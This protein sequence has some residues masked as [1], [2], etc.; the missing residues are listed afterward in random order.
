MAR[1]TSRLRSAALPLLAVAAV[2]APPDAGAQT[3]ALGVMLG[4]VSSAHARSR[5][6]GSKRHA[7]FMVGAWIDVATPRPWLSVTAE[8]ALARRGAVYPFDDGFDR[9]LDVDYLTAALLPTL[10]I[11][12]GP[13]ALVGYAGPSVDVLIRSGASIELQDA[14]RSG[15]GQVLG[16]VAGG[17][18]QYR[19]GRAT[20]RLE[21][22]VH[23]QFTRAFEGEF[24]D[25]RHH[26][27][28]FVFRLGMRPVR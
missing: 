19:H 16:G 11:P 22:R 25:V 4:P 17:G 26:S 14:F 24:D 3:K 23:R 9:Q 18:L 10:G 20:F 2:A 28:E 6:V 12:V 13:F 7:G 8:A 21:A 1:P 15:T 27:T 5:E